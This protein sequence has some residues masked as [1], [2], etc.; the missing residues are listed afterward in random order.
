MLVRLEPGEEPAEL[1]LGD[2]FARVL[3]VRH[4]LP[5]CQRMR[6]MRP[7]VVLVG[8]S[9]RQPDRDMLMEQACDIG[10]VLLCLGPLVRREALGKWV[11]DAMQA[12]ARRRAE[13]GEDVLQIAAGE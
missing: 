13:R 9:V 7:L 10:A 11:R 1:G 2:L 8:E 12:V 5:A 4:P 6:I 3:R